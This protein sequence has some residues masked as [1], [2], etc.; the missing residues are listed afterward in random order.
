MQ[1][2]SLDHR[3]LSLAKSLFALATTLATRATALTALHATK[4]DRIQK[5]VLAPALAR[6]EGFLERSGLYDKQA[7]VPLKKN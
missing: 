6:Q 4:S 5:C 2:S 3:I 1:Y 7:S